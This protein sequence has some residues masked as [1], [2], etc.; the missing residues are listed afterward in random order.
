VPGVP[1]V[2]AMPGEGA[3]RGCG[4]PAG[5]SWF[6]AVVSVT[7]FVALVRFQRDPF[8]VMGSCAGL[9]LCYTF[10]AG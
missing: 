9:G 3:R 4:R 5:S 2:G 1:S 10:V 6:A 8:E 7:A